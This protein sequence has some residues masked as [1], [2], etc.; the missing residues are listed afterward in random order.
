MFGT[1][2]T[3]EELSDRIIA[4]ENVATLAGFAHK[5]GTLRAAGDVRYRL[6]NVERDAARVAGRILRADGITATRATV[7]ATGVVLADALHDAIVAES[8]RVA[9]RNL[10]R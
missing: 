7:A 2:L 10:A 8:G 1:N 4:G 3:P 9:G 5:W 6:E